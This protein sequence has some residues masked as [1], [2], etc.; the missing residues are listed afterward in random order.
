M[1]VPNMAFFE[2]VFASRWVCNTE[3]AESD[4]SIS[5]IIFS[6]FTCFLI[7]FVHGSPGPGLS[8]CFDICFEACPSADADAT[9][10]NGEAS[11]CNNTREE[12]LKQTKLVELKPLHCSLLVS[13][14]WYPS[15]LPSMHTTLGGEEAQQNLPCKMW[16]K[17]WQ[18]WEWKMW[19]T[20]PIWR[21]TKW[22]TFHSSWQMWSKLWQT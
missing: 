5:L 6:H 9:A 1:R 22:P 17:T 12:C 16:S 7:S 21:S 4:S 19:P 11:L 13:S 14:G 10:C 15:N 3:T 18:T 8:I 20:K 2:S